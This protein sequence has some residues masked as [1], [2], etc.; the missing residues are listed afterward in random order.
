MLFPG[1]WIKPIAMK[2]HERLLIGVVLFCQ[3]VFPP[4]FVQMM[5]K[6]LR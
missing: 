5:H 2:R 6:G 3:G 1:K 4:C